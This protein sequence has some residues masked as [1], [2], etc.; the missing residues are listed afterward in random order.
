MVMLFCFLSALLPIYIY[1]LVVFLLSDCFSHPWLC[2]GHYATHFGIRFVKR[3]N[4]KRVCICILWIRLFVLK[5]FSKE[6]GSFNMYN[7]YYYYFLN[8]LRLFNWK[9]KKKKTQNANLSLKH[10]ETNVLHLSCAN[11]NHDVYTTHGQN[12]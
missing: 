4:F 12:N 6:I 1:F 8:L 3:L 2:S 11:A 7:Y 10:S 9:W 5:Y